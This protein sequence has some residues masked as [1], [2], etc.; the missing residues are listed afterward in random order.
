MQIEIFGTKIRLT[1]TSII[2]FPNGNEVYVVYCDA[3]RIGV[4]CF[5]MQHGKVI[6]YTSSQLQKH[7][8]I[9]TT[10]DHE[11]DRVLCALIIWRHYIYNI[12]IDIFTYHPSLQFLL[13]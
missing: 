5:V 7:E 2:N 10:H 8:H 6:E 1:T 11:L 3:S 4:G 12:H 13:K 9:H